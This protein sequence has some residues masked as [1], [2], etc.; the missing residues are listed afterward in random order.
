MTINEQEYIFD[1][2][3]ENDERELI[4]FEDKRQDIREGK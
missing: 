3:S 2:D 4:A 1:P